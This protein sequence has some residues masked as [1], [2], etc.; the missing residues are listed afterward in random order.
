LLVWPFAT[1]ELNSRVEAPEIPS[2]PVPVTAMT[3]VPAPL[4]FSKRPELVM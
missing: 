3:L 4:V 1:D 2:V